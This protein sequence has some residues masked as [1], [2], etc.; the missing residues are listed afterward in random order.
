MND[1]M[2]AITVQHHGVPGLNIAPGSTSFRADSAVYK[3]TEIGDRIT[4]SLTPEDGVYTITGAEPSAAP[5]D[6]PRQ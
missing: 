4:F 3:R 6:V 5:D 1:A 2:G